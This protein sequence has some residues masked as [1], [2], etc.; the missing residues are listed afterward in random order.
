SSVTKPIS[1]SVTDETLGYNNAGRYPTILINGCNAGQ[2]FNDDV[3]FGEDWILAENRGALGVIA[4]SSFGFTSTLRRYTD[5]FYSFGYSNDQFI[6]RPIAEIQKLV[7][8]EYISQVGTAP[9]NIAQARQMVLLGDPAIQLFA[10]DRSDYEINDDNV[11]V[12]SFDEQP[13]SAQAD[14]FA[15]KL[16]V[17]NFGRFDRDSVRVE[18]RRTLSDNTIITTDSLFKAVLFQDTLTLVINNED[19][20]AVGANQF[21]VS[22]DPLDSISELNEGNNTANF[23]F[24]LQL[25]GTQN[26]YPIDFS[27]VNTQPVELFVQSSDLLGPE[28]DFSIEIDTVNTFDSPFLRQNT[29]NSR[30]LASWTTELL[31]NTTANDSTV[32]FWRSRFTDIQPGESDEWVTSSFIYINNGGEGWSQSIF[33]QYDDNVLLGLERNEEFESLDF[34]TSTTDV[35]VSTRGS[36]APDTLVRSFKIN[37]VEFLLN[38][39]TACRNNTLNLVA[40]NGETSV[41]YAALPLPFQSSPKICGRSPLIINSFRISEFESGNDNLL[42]YIDAVDEG[43]SVVIFT[44]GNAGF[45]SWSDNI[46]TQ[47]GEL[48]LST[49]QIDGLTNG[50]PLIVFGRKGIDPGDAQLVKSTTAPVTEQLIE[51][52][53]TVTGVFANGTM[54]SPLIGP[55]LQWQ[56][57]ITDISISESPQTDNFSVS[58]IGVDLAGEETIIQ[59]DITTSSFDLT[60]I[61]PSTFPFLRLRYNT[62][63]PLN[64]TPAI[65]NKWQVIYESVPEGIV[66]SDLD[67][68]NGPE[69]QEG[70]VISLNFGFKNISSKAFTDSLEV[71]YSTF[72]QPSRTNSPLSLKIEA[73]LP[74]DTTE[75]VLDIDTRG[76]AGINDFN[77][78]VNPRVEPEQYYNNNL[79]DLLG[80]IQVNEDEINPVIDV[81]FDGE[82][83]LDGDIVSPS[84]LI[85]IKLRDENE[86]LFKTDTVGFNIFLKQ[87]CEGCDFERV[88]F[89]SNQIEWT[90]ASEGNDFRVL[91]QPESLVDAIYTLRIDA[92][93]ATGN[94]VGEDPFNINFEVINESTITN[95]YPYPNPFSTSTR[96]VFTLTGS[97]I[98][99]KIKI[100]IMTVSGKVVR[101]ITQDELGAIRIGNNLTD[102]AWDGK[103]EFGDQLANGVYLYRVII[104]NAGETID[105]RDTSA[106]RAF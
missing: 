20:N 76:K 105:H 67:L 81:V 82:Y 48:G 42:D 87:D 83:I 2:F 21:L 38:N 46:K 98:P 1:I 6:N 75:F 56:T 9:A 61:N 31:P 88:P 94:S 37:D 77:L 68:S 10:A 29:V 13:V 52:E 53:R 64:L 47:L 97:E 92:S 63:D 69:A 103:D 36:A 5:L 71:N 60:T 34:L 58:I 72:N 70:E 3:L 44:L 22:I 59:G 89:S 96:F 43:D 66:L 8:R 40:F 85:A 19:V 41:P 28:R 30:L 51:A 78:F 35:F 24:F 102:Y 14:S 4:H 33:D 16:I 17:N 54:T 84:P 91:Y 106:D 99:D 26:L 49:T 23:D 57:L 32:Y 80:L 27:I 7:A 100:Q 11:F 74:G 62:N 55:A 73:P 79:L 93:D 95:F 90:P 101:E 86:F 25:F 104:R 15:L 18:V 12:E 50:E 45:T 65:I 39:V